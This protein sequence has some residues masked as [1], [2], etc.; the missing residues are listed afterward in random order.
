MWFAVNLCC[1]STLFVELLV[2]SVDDVVWWL[3]LVP[4]GLVS[5]FLKVD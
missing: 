1:G 2:S 4:S 5:I 3:E